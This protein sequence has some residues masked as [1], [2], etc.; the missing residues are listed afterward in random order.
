M[1][2]ERIDDI[3]AA[4]DRLRGIAHVTPI[5]T[6]RTLDERAGGPVFLKCENLQRVGAF[7]IRGAY[8]A[9]SRAPAR[10]AG[11]GGAHLLVRQPR[12]GHRARRPAAGCPHDG[13]DAA[14]GSGEQEAATLGYGARVVE[15]DPASTTARRSPPACPRRRRR[16]SSRRM[17]IWT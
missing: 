11:G 4:R 10:A 12:A 14:R 1:S 9:L 16:L 17:T 8:N 7:K 3:Q 13:G 15:F 2:R 5:A 6:S